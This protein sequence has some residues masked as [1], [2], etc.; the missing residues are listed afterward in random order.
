[1]LSHPKTGQ[2]VTGTCFDKTKPALRIPIHWITMTKH[3]LRIR[4]ASVKDLDA[5]LAIEERCFSKGSYRNHC[6]DRSQYRYYLRNSNAI[7]LVVIRDG[8]IAGSLVATAGQGARS[9][10]ARIISIAVLRCIRR[11]GA[12]RRLLKRALKLLHERGCQR[13]FLESAAEKKPAVALFQS[14]GFKVIRCL[15]NYYGDHIDGLRMKLTLS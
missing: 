12:G 15:P 9:G 3:M 7:A 10:T 6:F 2:S 5:L 14:I 1:M 13:I 4:T 8:T 11:E